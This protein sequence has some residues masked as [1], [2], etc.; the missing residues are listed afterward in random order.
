M[1]KFNSK[2]FNS[3]S[4]PVAKFMTWLCIIC[5]FFAFA[6]LCCA[7]FDFQGYRSQHLIAAAIFFAPIAILFGASWIY[8]I[9]LCIKNSIELK[10]EAIKN[11]GRDDYTP[12]EL[13]K[14]KNASCGNAENS[15]ML[16]TIPIQLQILLESLNDAME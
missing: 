9:V 7:L 4:G 6:N 12:E 3:L 11:L 15:S 14:E 8:C 16:T 2:E 13:A 1:S 10:K 5:G